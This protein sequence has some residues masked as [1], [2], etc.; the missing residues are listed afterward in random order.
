MNWL[1]WL[2]FAQASG[3]ISGNGSVQEYEG[4]TE[5]QEEL[6]PSH[7]LIRV[8]LLHLFTLPF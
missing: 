4:I 3:D 8:N 2:D 5:T 7:L 1:L 6:M